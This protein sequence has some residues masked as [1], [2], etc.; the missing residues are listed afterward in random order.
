MPSAEPSAT[1]A[2]PPNTGNITGGLVSLRSMSAGKRLQMYAGMAGWKIRP[3]MGGIVVRD[4]DDRAVGAG[5]PDLGDDVAGAERQRSRGGTGAGRRSGRPRSWP[6][7]QRRLTAPSARLPRPAAIPAGAAA[8]PVSRASG[9]PVL[10]VHALLF[11]PCADA[12]SAKRA[13]THS[14]AWRSPSR[15]GRPLDRRQLLDE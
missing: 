10:A 1:S 2:G 13:A 9:Q 14:A 8:A 4:Q 11:D 6:P 12:D 7:R 5:G 15:R 3:G